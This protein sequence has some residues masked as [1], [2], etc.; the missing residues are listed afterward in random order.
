MISALLV[1]GDPGSKGSLLEVDPTDQEASPSS[2]AGASGSLETAYRSWRRQQYQAAAI[3]IFEELFA[4]V[5]EKVL[6]PF[7]LSG[8]GFC[9]I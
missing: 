6:R 2:T 4:K 7:E 5:K 1:K 3:D 9:G 8:E